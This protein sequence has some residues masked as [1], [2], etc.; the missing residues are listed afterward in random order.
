MSSSSNLNHIEWARM[1]VNLLL[2]GG[3]ILKVLNGFLIQPK[4]LSSLE[5]M[6]FK[7]W[8]HYLKIPSQQNHIQGFQ[9]IRKR[10]IFQ[11]RNNNLSQKKYQQPVCCE[12]LKVVEQLYVV[13]CNCLK[14]IWVMVD[15]NRPRSHA[16]K[17]F[18]LQKTWQSNREI[19]TL[20]L[21]GITD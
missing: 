4:G 15:Q 5:A 3:C 20:I 17:K 13:R 8:K 9:S 7:F 19:A 11:T 21:D 1:P 6:K 14:I 12:H 16:I 18:S 2:L 10:D